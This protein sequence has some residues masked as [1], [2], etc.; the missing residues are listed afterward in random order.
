MKQYLTLEVENY[1][2]T[3]EHFLRTHAGLTRRQ[4]SQAKFR[5]NGIL[6]NGIHCRVTEHIASGD[7]ISVCLAEDTESSSHLA[8]PPAGMRPLEILYEDSDI[9]AVN[10]PSGVPVHPSGIHFND[11]LA[12]QIFSY[13]SSKGEALCCRSVGRLD[14]ETSGV[15]L[16]AKNRAAAS[17]LQKQKIDGTFRKQY[18]AAASGCLPADKGKDQH[19]I[20]FPI[21]ADPC[22]PLKMMALKSSFEP[23]SLHTTRENISKYAITHYHTL[24]STPDWSLVVLWLETGRT[25][26]IR[27][28]MDALGHPLLGDS[29]YGHNLKAPNSPHFSRAALHAWKAEFLQPF[30]RQRIFLQAS[31]PDDFAALKSFADF[32]F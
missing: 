18:L 5:E 21:A 16:F 20:K 22:N 25:H 31:L 1:A 7:T 2:G 3:V 32:E 14:K 4:I 12:N 27:V 11:T 19:T 23:F 13:S 6:K 29:L 26:Q 28:H 17:I 10:K 9:I 24:Y 30:T 15:V 8:A